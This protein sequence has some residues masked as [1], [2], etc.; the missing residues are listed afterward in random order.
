[1]AYDYQFQPDGYIGQPSNNQFADLPSNWQTWLW[2][3]HRLLDP[4]DWMN[5]FDMLFFESGHVG[6]Y[7]YGPS[8]EDYVFEADPSH[9]YT[10]ALPLE[11]V[12]AREGAVTAIGRILPKPYSKRY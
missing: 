8:G 2:H 3:S 10:K 5:E 6:L 11:T 7:V 12:V 1:M 9:A 4:G